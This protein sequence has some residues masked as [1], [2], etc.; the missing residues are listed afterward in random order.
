M[1]YEWRFPMGIPAQKAG[2]ELERIERKHGALTAATV[3]DESRDSKAVLHPCFEWDDT[4]AAEKYRLSQARCIIA[5]LTVTVREEQRAPVRAFV[6]VA[7][8]RRD[9]GKFIN[10][11]AAL[12]DADMRRIV[13]RHAIAE[14]ESFLKKY[15]GLEE[16]A[17]IFAAIESLNLKRVA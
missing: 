16:L 7:E 2:A 1:V 14:L 4:K 10:V 17:E 3:L 8:T 15:R 9:E 12:S 13:I 6:N 5:S 11:A